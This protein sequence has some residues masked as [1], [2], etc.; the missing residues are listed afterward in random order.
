MAAADLEHRR[1][2]RSKR[3]MRSL[4][5]I[6]AL[7]FVIAAF[8]FGVGLQ[9]ATAAATSPVIAWP[10]TVVTYASQIHDA[11]YRAAIASAVKAWNGLKVGVIFERSGGPTEVTFSSRRGPC[12]LGRAGYAPYGFQ[13]STAHVTLSRSCPTLVRQLLVSHELGRVLGLPIDDTRCSLMNSHALSDGLTYA[14]PARCSRTHPPKW[15]DK[16]VDP[17]TASL[18]RQIYALPPAP[19]EISLSL[20]PDGLPEVSWDE[21]QTHGVA[22]SKIARNATS[23]PT[24]RD[25]ARHTAT[26]LYDAA[27]SAGH[28]TLLDSAFPTSGAVQCFRNFSAS[29]YGRAAPSPD[30]TT[31][32][33][34]GPLAGFT[35]NGA[36]AGTPTS[37]TDSSVAPQGGAI[38]SWSWNFGDPASGAANTL[39]TTDSAIGEAPSHTYASA[40]IYAVTLSVTDG[41]SRNSTKLRQIVIA[42]TP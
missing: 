12:L 39:T 1:A 32:G 31:F 13:I 15:L 26:I 36:P 10:G 4:V 20:S 42:G 28:H 22:A 35:V 2:V 27:P 33:F 41:T 30:T 24:D 38:A 17:R 23:C 19:T 9:G 5:V 11:S 6:A 7:L 18:A 16:L 29:A 14:V 3:S 40:G 21:V 37:F 34:G 25:I 8:P